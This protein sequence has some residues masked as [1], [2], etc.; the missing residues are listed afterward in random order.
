MTLPYCNMTRS[1]TL[2]YKRLA[3]DSDKREEQKLN[4]DSY[5]II[6]LIDFYGQLLTDNQLSC[7]DMHY[8]NDM[9]LA[10]IADE[11]G[12]SRQGAFDFIKRGR[13]ALEQYESQLGLVKRFRETKARLEGVQNDIARVKRDSL[14]G[15]DCKVLSKVES[16]LSDII[17]KL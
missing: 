14:D 6:M 15:G 10:E 9:S 12:I 4:M 11:L 1:F 16:E 7:L 8:N 2:Q 3:C 17:G 5:E 13:A